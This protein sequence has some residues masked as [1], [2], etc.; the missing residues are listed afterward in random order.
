MPG[1]IVELSDTFLMKVPLAPLGL[2]RLI[3]FTSA[4]TLAAIASSLNE[5]LPGGNFNDRQS[6]FHKTDLRLSYAPDSERWSA[7]LW[8][9]NLENDAQLTQ[10][11]PFGRVQI[12]DPRTWGVNLSYKF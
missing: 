1:P 3:A 7:G 8:V 5:A 2:A 9:R 6:R 10:S 11:M 4:F 12:T